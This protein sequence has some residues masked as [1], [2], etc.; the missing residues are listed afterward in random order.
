MSLEDVLTAVSGIN[1]K[2]DSLRQDVDALME[3]RRARSRS[4]RR[5][6]PASAR[7]ASGSSGRP[8]SYADATR[9]WADRDPMEKM[10]YSAPISF[11]DEE[12]VGDESSEQLVEVSE[13]TERLLTDSCTRSVT[14]V[15]RKHTRSSFRL[16]RVPATRTPRLDYFIKVETSQP[17]K[18]L[19]KEQA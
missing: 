13:K 3:D 2:F 14:N 10:D 19:D 16:P 8:V 1:E 6:S 9:D 11:S 7:R 12:D 18:T 17:A 15:S 4:P 5:K